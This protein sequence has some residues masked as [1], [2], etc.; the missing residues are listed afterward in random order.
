MLF[1]GKDVKGKGR[2][3]K[4][5]GRK[6]QGRKGTG[7]EN[8]ESEKVNKC[9]IGKNKGKKAVIGVENHKPTREETLSF[10]GKGGGEISFS[11]Q[12]ID[13]QCVENSYP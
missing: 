10:F 7:K 5:I 13:P 3:G 4:G 11:N 2:K 9:K 8:I 6:E 1:G 12:N